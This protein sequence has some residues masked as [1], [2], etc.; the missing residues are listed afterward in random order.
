[1]ASELELVDGV[2]L[3][4]LGTELSVCSFCCTVRNA[5]GSPLVRFG[6]DLCPTS[7]HESMYYGVSLVRFLYSAMRVAPLH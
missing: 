7:L 1:M 6:A 4:L 3:F 5:R 2:S